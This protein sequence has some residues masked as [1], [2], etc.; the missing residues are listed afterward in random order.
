L[1]DIVF[2]IRDG[3]EKFLKLK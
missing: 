2:S 1:S 3:R